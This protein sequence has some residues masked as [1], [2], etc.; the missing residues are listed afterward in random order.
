M[1]SYSSIFWHKK[2][3]FRWY[4][5]KNDLFIQIDMAEFADP[6]LQ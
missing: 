2:T 6:H 4:W 3:T 5:F 1:S